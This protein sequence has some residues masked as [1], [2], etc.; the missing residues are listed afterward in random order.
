MRHNKS[1]D[2]KCVF[3]FELSLPFPHNV[4]ESRVTHHDRILHH[5][6]A[7]LLDVPPTYLTASTSRLPSNLPVRSPSSKLGKISRKSKG[8]IAPTALALNQP[9][10]RPE[11]VDEIFEEGSARRSKSSEAQ[12]PR[13]MCLESTGALWSDY[14]IRANCTF[15]APVTW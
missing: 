11:L 9:L 14:L 6:Q 3:R 1:H 4:P 5:V 10:D 7:V 2:A 13:A 8:K 12:A 15:A